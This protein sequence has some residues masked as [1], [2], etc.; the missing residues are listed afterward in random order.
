MSV[1]FNASIQQF[2]ETGRDVYPQPVAT[3]CGRVLRAR[4]QESLL[5]AALKAG[6]VLARYLAALA[7]SSYACRRTDPQSIPFEA[8]RFQ[9]HLAFGDFLELTQSI[10]ISDC[11]HPLRQQF[12][13]MD[14]RNKKPAKVEKT[15]SAALGKLLVCRNDRGHE[16]TGL[17]SAQAQSFL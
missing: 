14:S 10:A 7:L 6:E 3:A 13:A 12:Q 9:K 15:A 8:E 4:S 16:L 1:E 17:N 5:E 2:L 11:D